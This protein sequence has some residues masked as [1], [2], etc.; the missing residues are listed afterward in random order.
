MEI[1]GFL[2]QLGHRLRTAREGAELTV[3]EAARRAGVSRRHWTETEAGRANPSIVV[4]ARQA[5]AVG[6]TVA[7]LVES[8]LDPDPTGDFD[9]Y[10]L[11]DDFEGVALA[12]KLARRVRAQRPE[13]IRFSRRS[14]SKLV[15]PVPA[16][17]STT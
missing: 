8:R 15:F 3:T 1:Q 6:S 2:E 5:S 4:L 16:P 17:A 14:T 12:G 10:F 11:D 13:A 7:E 9:L